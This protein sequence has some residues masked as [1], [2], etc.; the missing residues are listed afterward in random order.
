[1]TMI[2]HAYIFPEPTVIQPY[3]YFVLC[4]DA[5]AFKLLNPDAKH[6]SGDLDFKLSSTGDVLRLYN[7]GGTL[8]DRVAYGSITPW[9]D[10]T[11]LEGSTLELID[12]GLDNA[13]PF[14][15]KASGKTGRKSGCH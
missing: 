2:E 13:L 6:I 3:N 7:A 15:W 4:R 14:N 11:G 5:Q 1:M 8:I 10:L 12:P 9:P